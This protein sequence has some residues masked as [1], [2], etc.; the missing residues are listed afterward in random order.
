MQIWCILLYCDQVI[1]PLHN[2]WQGFIWRRFLIFV[3]DAVV[4]LRSCTS[5]SRHCANWINHP[6]YYLIQHT[7]RTAI[8]CNA[9]LP[10]QH[11][12]NFCASHDTT[13][14]WYTFA[15]L[16]S[17]ASQS[18]SRLWVYEIFV[19]VPVY[20]SVHYQYSKLDISFPMASWMLK[21]VVATG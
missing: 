20:V 11:P 9:Y 12:A 1:G 13:D 10:S 8:I 4:L 16:V 14:Y 6:S 3:T 2:L 18:V 17:P 15:F 5:N 19:H 7:E 21:K